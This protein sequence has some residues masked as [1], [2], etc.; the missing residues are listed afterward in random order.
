MDAFVLEMDDLTETD[1]DH[2]TLPKCVVIDP[3]QEARDREGS[4]GAVT[5]E[6]E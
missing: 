4:P 5:I 6:D 3:F 2:R 1:V